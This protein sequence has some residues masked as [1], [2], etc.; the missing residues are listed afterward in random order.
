MATTKTL[1]I[2][3]ED[4]KSLNS[5]DKNQAHKFPEVVNYK[6]DDSALKV[7]RTP[8]N[9]RKL[10]EEVDPQHMTRKEY[11][12][13][14]CYKF[15]FNVGKGWDGIERHAHTPNWTL[16]PSHNIK[17]RDEALI[18]L[19]MFNPTLPNNTDN[20]LETDRRTNPKKGLSKNKRKR[21]RREKEKLL[22]KQEDILYYSAI[23]LGFLTLFA[24]YAITIARFIK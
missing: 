15:G 18:F 21:I 12:H 19:G 11:I 14:L 2:E 3:N 10:M 16:E 4:D 23:G 24:T 6:F 20:R 17:T 9:S 5:N 13:Y 7:G 8:I 1:T 22:R